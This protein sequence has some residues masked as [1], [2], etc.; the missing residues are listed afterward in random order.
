MLPSVPRSYTSRR[1]HPTLGS[2]TASLV[3]PWLSVG[4]L[5]V[6]LG[7]GPFAGAGEVAGRVIEYPLGAVVGSAQLRAE[8]VVDHGLDVRLWADAGQVRHVWPGD[9]RGVEGGERRSEGHSAFEFHKKGH[10]SHRDARGPDEG[11]K[12]VHGVSRVA[13][14]VGCDWAAVDQTPGTG[15]SAIVEL[16]APPHCRGVEHGPER[17]RGGGNEEDDGRVPLL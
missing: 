9:S 5:L 11:G 13:G 16:D 4:D 15:R 2:N 3:T 8:L 7:P 10:G 14:R 17:M 12:E 1:A 6:E